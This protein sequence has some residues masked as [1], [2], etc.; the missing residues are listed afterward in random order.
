[1]RYGSSQVSMPPLTT[2]VVSSTL[3]RLSI[4]A[5][6]LAAALAA[7]LLG[8]SAA[9]TLPSVAAATDPHLLPAPATQEEPRLAGLVGLD[10]LAVATQT[11][12]GLRRLPRHDPPE[13]SEFQ[14]EASTLVAEPQPTERAGGR[15]PGPPLRVLSGSQLQHP[16]SSSRSITTRLQRIFSAVDTNGSGAIAIPPRATPS[17]DPSFWAP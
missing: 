3:R 17:R 14:S 12:S 11:L 2:A 13:A 16:D 5:L 10:G 9:E 8:A 1:M 6:V 7:C 4:L 15:E